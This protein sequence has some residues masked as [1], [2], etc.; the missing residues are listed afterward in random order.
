[1][2]VI[3]KPIMYIPIGLDVN[4]QFSN[5]SITNKAIMQTMPVIVWYGAVPLV[6]CA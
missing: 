1:M 4:F 5:L 3:K 6:I 2:K